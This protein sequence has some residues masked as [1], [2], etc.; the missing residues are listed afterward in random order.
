MRQSKAKKL[1][2]QANALR[3]DPEAAVNSYKGLKESIKL[4]SA[5]MSSVNV[6]LSKKRHVGESHEDFIE[7]RRVCNRRRRQRERKNKL[8]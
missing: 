7:R 6:Q 4:K 3:L 5:V 8:M 2:K 1:R